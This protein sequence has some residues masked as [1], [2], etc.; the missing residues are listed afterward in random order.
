MDFHGDLGAVERLTLHLGETDD[1][2]QVFGAQQGSETFFLAVSLDFFDAF[3]QA[4]AHLAAFTENRNN[5]ALRQ[6]KHRYEDHSQE[7]E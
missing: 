2:L 1:V 7:Y 3:F 5:D 4:L 6:Q